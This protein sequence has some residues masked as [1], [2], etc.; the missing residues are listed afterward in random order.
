LSTGISRGRDKDTFRCPGRS[1][2]EHFASSTGGESYGVGTELRNTGGA[3]SDG[4]GDWIGDAT[5]R[6]GAE[7]GGECFLGDDDCVC[8]ADFD[9]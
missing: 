8:D 6:V 9:G 7:S 2:S 5:S 3:R 4:I 1:V